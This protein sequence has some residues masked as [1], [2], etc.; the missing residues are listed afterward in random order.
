[1]KV[2]CKDCDCV[3]DAQGDYI[4]AESHTWAGWWHKPYTCY[5]CGS[6]DVVRTDEP[7]RLPRGERAKVKG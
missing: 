4:E 2:R 7:Y 5:N 1:M 6:V 3:I